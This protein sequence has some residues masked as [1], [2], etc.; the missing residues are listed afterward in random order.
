MKVVSRLRRI[1][2][3]NDL[4]EKNMPQDLINQI[5]QT[6]DTGVA[7][8]STIF[9][10]EMNSN[11]RFVVEIW[12]LDNGTFGVFSGHFE[13]QWNPGIIDYHGGFT[14]ETEAQL[15]VQDN[16]QGQ[17]E[18][19]ENLLASKKEIAKKLMAAGKE[20]EYSDLAQEFLKTVTIE[21][22]KN[23]NKYYQ[24]WV[25]YMNRYYPEWAAY[26]AYIWRGWGYVTS[27]VE[28]QND[29]EDNNDTKEDNNDNGNHDISQ[30]EMPF[31]TPGADVGVIPSADFGGDTL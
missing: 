6:Q 23:V 29:K 30:E 18:S 28:D 13:G 22:K 25:D 14:S 8:E 5:L 15:Y 31:N 17:A 10:K 3:I 16:L 4:G 1:A 27:I 9:R 19:K 12:S 7:S 26:P 11:T 24:N 21:D 2:S 20:P